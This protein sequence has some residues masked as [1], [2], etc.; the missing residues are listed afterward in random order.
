[1]LKIGVKPYYCYACDLVP[2]SSHF[3]VPLPKLLGI[4][5]ELRGWIS[6]YAI[7]HFVIDGPGGRGKTPILPDYFIGE[8]GQDYLFRNYKGEK[9]T[10][11]AA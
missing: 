2:G 4:I 6:G 9:F 1:L 8:N 5:D 3:R 10:Y 11:P 7:P